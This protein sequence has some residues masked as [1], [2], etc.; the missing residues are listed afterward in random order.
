M[1]VYTTLEIPAKVVL[2]VSKE[3]KVKAHVQCRFAGKTH[4]VYLDRTTNLDHLIE[5]VATTFGA[6]HS[7]HTNPKRE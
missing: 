4:T 2:R 1:V 3:G 5:N 7:E 6:A